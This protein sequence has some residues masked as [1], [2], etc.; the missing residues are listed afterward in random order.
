[1][2]SPETAL[3]EALQDALRRVAR[4]GTLLVALDFDGTLAPHV[5][6]PE[7]ARAIPASAEAVRALAAL[8][9]TPVALVSGRAL[10][11][12]VHVA[13]PAPELLL[14]GSHGIELRLGPDDDPVGLD[15]R[16]RER[17][18][19]LE[20]LLGEI[21]AA[22][23]GTW[24]ES[25]PAGFALHTRRLDES[26]A[27]R[28]QQQ[29]RERV[30]AGIGDLTVRAGKDVIEFA[31]RDATKGDAIVRLREA[32]GADAVLYAGDDVTDEDGFAALVPGDVAIKVGE[33]ETRA[34]FRVAD[35]RAM[36][37]VLAILLEA[38]R[39]G[40]VASPA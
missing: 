40:R 33:G 20:R 34:G 22:S 8:P 38:R 18:D 35:P 4:V 15:A 3:P 14:V 2:S 5:D 39:G 21:A 12:L 16:E 13:E 19:A 23:E 17:R 6:S 1:M 10:E 7:D 31:I 29:A 9:A 24:V 36:T 25:K 30:D 37:R 32:T 11:S 28:V 27:R 26:T